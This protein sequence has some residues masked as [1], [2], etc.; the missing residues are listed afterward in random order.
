MNAN[1][2]QTN[3]QQLILSLS[4]NKTVCLLIFLNS[5]SFAI[6]IL[7]VTEDG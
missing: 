3:T 7:T 4:Y 1:N 2:M 5:S 6:C